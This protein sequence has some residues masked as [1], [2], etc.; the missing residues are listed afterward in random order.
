MKLCLKC[1]EKLPVFHFPYFS[2][3]AS[4][5]PT[6]NI[7]IEAPC[8]PIF[9]VH[10]GIHCQHSAPSL[11]GVVLPVDNNNIYIQVTLYTSATQN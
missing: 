7:G 4:C 8:K 5:A 6:L 3:G 10:I 11:A 9:T 1:N 2:P